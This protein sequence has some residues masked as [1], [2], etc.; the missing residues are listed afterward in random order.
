MT[1]SV[2]YVML[3]PGLGTY[4][5]VL[6]W[7]QAGEISERLADYDARFGA[8]RRRILTVPLATLAEDGAAMRSAR[9]IFSNHCS[10][11]HGAD[12]NGQAG[13]FPDL[14]DA[15]WQWGADEPQLIHTIRS[16]RMAVMPGWLAIAGEPGVGQLTDYVLSMSRGEASLPAV[17]PGA[18]L[19]Q[20]FCMA[21]HGADG[22][23]NALLGAPA[24]ND[25][26]WTYGGSRAQVIESIAKGRNGVM[27]EFGSRL[28]ETQ[29]RLLAAWLQAG[30]PAP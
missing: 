7:S 30:A 8:E 9:R 4:R 21:C 6:E 20:Q 3:Y 27:P 18:V 1:V 24:L 22:G 19:F 25:T 17:A 13:Q 11:C 15:A 28:D 26:A 10:T 5:G 29:I 14:T 12:A 2:I 16:G 23:G